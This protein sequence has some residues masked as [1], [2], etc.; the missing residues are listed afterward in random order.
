MEANREAD[1]GWE[2]GDVQVMV[3]ELA[4]QAS[5]DDAAEVLQDALEA[6][7]AADVDDLLA[8]NTELRAALHVFGMATDGAL[9]SAAAVDAANSQLLRSLSIAANADLR[10]LIAP[11]Q[12]PTPYRLRIVARVLEDGRIEHGVDLANGLRVLP[13]IRY[14][15]TNASV[16]QW[17]TSSSI[18]V[19]GTEIGKTPTRRLADGRVEL[20]FWTADGEAIEPEVRYLPA[21]PPSDVWLRSGE[22]EVLLE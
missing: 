10:N 3:A 15:A 12:A 11:E 17:R 8:L 9:C 4:G 21:D 18:E 13:L 1:E 16:D 22:I 6:A 5:C 14:L 7:D 19:G 2:D 20:G